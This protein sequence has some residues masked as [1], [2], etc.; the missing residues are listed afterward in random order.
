MRNRRSEGSML[1]K[2]QHGHARTPP[3]TIAH[4]LWSDVLALTNRAHTSATSAQPQHMVCKA[5]GNFQQLPRATR[6]RRKPPKPNTK[7]LHRRRTCNA[8]MKRPGPPANARH[9]TNAHAIAKLTRSTRRWPPAPQDTTQPIATMR[10]TRGQ[11]PIGGANATTSK[12]RPAPPM[13]ITT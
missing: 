8:S 1:P 4:L 3:H 11:L 10:Q 9:K 2:M 5:D 13:K 7:P 12:L 6:E